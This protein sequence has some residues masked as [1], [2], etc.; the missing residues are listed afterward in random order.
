MK[1]FATSLL[2]AVAVVFSAA[3]AQAQVPYVTY[4]QP[5]VVTPRVTY[6]SAPTRYYSYYPSTTYT[7]YPPT[8]TYSTAPVVTRYRP[9]LGGMVQRYVSNYVPTYYYSY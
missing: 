1:R 8:S 4:Y 2:I 3:A 9:V 7:Y 6:Y 5:S